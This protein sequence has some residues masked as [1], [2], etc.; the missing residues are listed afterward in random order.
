MI[1]VKNVTFKYDREKRNVLN[2]VSFSVPQG[3]W[4]SIIGH[5][6]CGKSTLAKI[7][8]GLITPTSGKVSINNI[9]LNKESI[10]KMRQ[11][12]GIIFQ[13]PDDQFVGATV[14]Y[15]LAFGMENLNLSRGDIIKKID[16]IS[17][18][19]NII[20]ILDKTPLELSGGQKQKVALAGLL[21]L[22]K[23]IFIFDEA[24]SMLD[25]KASDQ[26]FALI[27]KLHEDGKT[28]IMITHDL[29]KAFASEK[30][31]LLKEGNVLFYDEPSKLYDNVSLLTSSN[32]DL[33]K[34]LMLLKELTTVN[35]TDKTFLKVKEILWNF[36]LQK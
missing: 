6:G 27:K 31:L 25:Q 22:D 14:R 15:D 26:I 1:E 2:N 18:D 21:A 32:L 7:L 24:L 34:P 12:M 30:I 10:S 9:V 16:K 20:S 19:F 5:N 36:L 35:L 4:I 28:I 11:R 23:D 33:P 3:S 17:K 29:G 8:M 13:N